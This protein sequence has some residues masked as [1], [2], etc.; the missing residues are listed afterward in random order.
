[1]RAKVTER[2]RSCLSL[3]AKAWPPLPQEFAHT[4]SE[5]LAEAVNIF[6]STSSGFAVDLFLFSETGS[7]HSGLELPTS[8]LSLPGARITDKPH[9]TLRSASFVAER[10]HGGCG[11]W[12]EAC[13]CTP[14]CGSQRSTSGVFPQGSST[15]DLR[16]G[17]SLGPD[18]H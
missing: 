17:F 2:A 18:T 8:S 5:L 10:G 6:S 16:Q 1:M 13:V 14:V 11:C 4:A 9:H 3:S 12:W 7:Y 15:F